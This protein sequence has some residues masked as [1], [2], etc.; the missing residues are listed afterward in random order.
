MKIRTDA[1]KS[2]AK[3]P[4]IELVN[5]SYAYHERGRTIGENG[6]CQFFDTIQ[7]VNT[8]MLEKLVFEGRHG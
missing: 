8:K 7:V 5:R 1:K 2:T 4:L 3:T 6:N